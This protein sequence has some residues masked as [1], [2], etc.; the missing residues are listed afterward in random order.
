MNR[1]RSALVQIF[2]L[3]CIIVLGL[4][5]CEKQSTDEAA[6]S[7]LPAMDSLEPPASE[8]IGI[9]SIPKAKAEASSEQPN[10][11]AA[12]V[13]GGPNAEWV[14]TSNSEGEW[15]RLSWDE[16]VTIQKVALQDR[17]NLKDQIM[18]GHLEFSDD[19]PIVEID[20]LPNDGS[21]L[22]SSFTPRQV[23]WV[24]FVIDQVSPETINVGLKEFGVE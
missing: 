8:P 13:Q 1:N 9:A 12:C 20:E 5:A 3:G 6:N 14:S 19:S 22:T 15:I 16:P 17:G 4:S 10:R 7:T 11:I 24:K 23:L 2:I 18:A 21:P